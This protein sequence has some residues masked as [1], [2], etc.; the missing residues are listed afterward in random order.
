MKCI[1]CNIRV[2]NLTDN[3]PICG[4]HLHGKEPGMHA[5]YPDIMD[6][7]R[8]AAILVKKIILFIAIVFTLLILVIN[9]LTGPSFLWSLIPI[10]GVWLL[11]LLIAVPVIKKKITPLMLI[12][13]SLIISGVLIALDFFTGGEGWSINYVVPGILFCFSFTVTVIIM[14]NRMTRK[15]FWLFQFSIAFICILPVLVRFFIEFV[16]WPSLVAAAYGFVT[17]AGMF[18][19]GDQTLKNEARK[20][21]HL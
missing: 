2:N 7:D 8:R 3:C 15:K 13:D 12:M 10:S 16:L 1:G 9:L 6:K 18:I 14:V 4:K 17:I 19:F 21:L 5:A 11:W 20:R